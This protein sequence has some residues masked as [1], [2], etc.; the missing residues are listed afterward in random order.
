MNKFNNLNFSSLN[1]LHNLKKSNRFNKVRKNAKKVMKFLSNLILVF[2]LAGSILSLI[3]IYWSHR[4]LN[5]LKK[6][7]A[8]ETKINTLIFQKAC[9]KAYQMHNKI[10]KKLN[11]A[12]KMV[13][14]KEL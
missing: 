12:K 7:L 14:E 8:A 13:P 4:Q 6:E 1:N 11:Q 2:L 5:N 3:G 9:L 10:K